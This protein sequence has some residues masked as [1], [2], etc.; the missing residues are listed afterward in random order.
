[1]GGSSAPGESCPQLT[2][3]SAPQG[4]PAP[5]R[6]WSVAHRWAPGCVC[7]KWPGAST[8]AGTAPVTPAPAELPPR[9]RQGRSRWAK[10]R[11]LTE[12]RLQSRRKGGSPALDPVFF[13]RVLSKHAAR[14]MR[15]RAC[16]GVPQLP[17]AG[18]DQSV[19]NYF[20]PQNHRSPGCLQ[21]A[22]S[23]RDGPGPL[24]AAGD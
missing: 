2:L 18:Q 10:N 16:A 15:A 8:G 21:D 20:S 9:H 7:R 13:T 3:H 11:H 6:A 19:E 12:L 24:Q 14:G 17:A 1:M 23:G 5:P 22:A 4:S